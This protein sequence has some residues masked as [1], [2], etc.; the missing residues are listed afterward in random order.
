MAGRFSKL[1]HFIPCNKNQHIARLFFR[2][3]IRLHGL[4]K[5]IVSNCVVKFMSYIWKT[6]WKMLNMTLKFSSVY[7]SQTDSQTEMVNRSSGNL[8]RCLV[9]DHVQLG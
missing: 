1:A 4:P 9:G 3:V 6:L 2:D 8:L 5:T 7:H